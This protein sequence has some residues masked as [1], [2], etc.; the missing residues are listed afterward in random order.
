MTVKMVVP[1]FPKTLFAGLIASRPA[2]ARIPSKA[3]SGRARACQTGRGHA[4][5]ATASPDAYFL[6]FLICYCAKTMPA[7]WA[8]FYPQGTNQL[9][10]NRV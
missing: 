4:I 2:R 3:A 5:Q 1:R 6:P 7:K 8:V 10:L 9:N